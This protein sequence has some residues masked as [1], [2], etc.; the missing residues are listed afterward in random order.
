VFAGKPKIGKSLFR[1]HMIAGCQRQGLRVALV[2]SERDVTTT[3][4]AALEALGVDVEALLHLGER[5]D[6]GMSY[7]LEDTLGAVAQAARADLLDAVFVDSMP[8]LI[9]RAQAEAIVRGDKAND[10]DDYLSRQARASQAAVLGQWLPGIA[11]VCADYGVSLFMV[12]HY[13]EKPDAQPYTDPRYLTGGYA[14]QHVA[15]G[16]F[17]VNKWPKSELRKAEKEVADN[18]WFFKLQLKES[19]L[20]PKVGE[21]IK[22]ALPL[23][24]PLWEST[25]YQQGAD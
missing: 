9:T 5:E 6:G 13:H 11:G 14:F 8:Y 7:V 10:A 18:H 24:C 19:R 21:E 2:A 22:V 20:S 17:W 1:T 15:S 23:N 4:D 12:T 16:I 25:L 3:G